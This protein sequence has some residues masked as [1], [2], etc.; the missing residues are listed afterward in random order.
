MQILSGFA[1]ILSGVTI[2]ILGLK[3]IS[4]YA[5]KL[6]VGRASQTLRSITKNKFVACGVG[7]LSTC[8]AQSSVATNMVALSFVQEG[9]L[10]ITSACA[11]V[12][13]TNVGT[14]ITAQVVS[15]SQSGI[16]IAVIGAFLAF[17]GMLF[18]GNKNRT[19]AN[20]ANVVM[21]FG[22]VFVGI[23]I[24]SG[25]VEL[26]KNTPWFMTVFLVKSPP[27]LLLNGFF[28]TMLCQSSSVVTS[29]LVI[30]A[31][32]NLLSLT[33]SIFLILGAN[34]GV[35][36][37]VLLM[38]RKNYNES[39]VAWFNL[40]FNLFGAIFFCIAIELSRGQVIKIFALS[41]TS[42][43][44]QIANFHTLFNLVVGVI[45]IFLLQPFVSLS[46]C[47]ANV[48]GTSATKSLVTSKKMMKTY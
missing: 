32:K 37:S 19:V 1:T 41:S 11:V 14:T 16:S 13:G 26:F 7:A 6:I 43:S 17:F 46:A 42:V 8:I 20:V 35:C 44:R 18:L 31:S 21:G 47:I 30:L 38:S 15:I 2:F 28:L 45:V 24:I 36:T 4:G 27:I 34:V 29:M 9:V 48:F 25:C 39:V 22:L 5:S 12:C 23:E 3:S 33:G 10:S 40:I